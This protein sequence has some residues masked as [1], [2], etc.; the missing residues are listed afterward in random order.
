M[1]LKDIIKQQ[2]DNLI[3]EEGVK[4][5]VSV[6]IEKDSIYAVFGGLLILTVF[7]TVAVLIVKNT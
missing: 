7:V 5:D 2:A 6:K 3:G 4:T 1:E